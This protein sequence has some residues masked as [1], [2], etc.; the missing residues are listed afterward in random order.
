M[1]RKDGKIHFRDKERWEQSKLAANIGQWN[2][3]IIDVKPGGDQATLTLNKDHTA[4]FPLMTGAVDQVQFRTN[5]YGSVL[6]DSL[7]VVHTPAR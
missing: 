7:M 3:F 1:I 2:T 4:H 6:L 5:G